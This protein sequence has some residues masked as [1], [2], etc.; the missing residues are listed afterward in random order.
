MKDK[1]PETDALLVQ[2]HQQIE[3]QKK[4]GEVRSE[5]EDLKKIRNENLDEIDTLE[6]EIDAMLSEEGII[7]DESIYIEDGC[8]DL[9]TDVDEEKIYAENKISNLDSI[10]GDIKDWESY[11]VSVRAYAERNN[12]DLDVDPFKSLMTESQRIEVSNRIQ[13]E[14]TYKKADCDKYDYMLAGTC[15]MIAGLVDIIFVGIPKQGSLGKK[16]DEAVDGAVQNF[17]KVL[18][19]QTKEGKDPTA[20]AIGFLEKKFKV[21]YDQTHTYKSGKAGT[22]GKVKNLYP[23]NHH[24]KSLG[25]SPDLIGLFFSILN[26]FTSTSTFISDG[27]LITINTETFELEGGN[28]PAKVYAGFCNWFGHLVS[29]VAGSSGARG[30]STRGSGIPIPFYALLQYIEVGKFGKNR[31]TFAKVSTKV[32]EQGYDFRHGVTMAIPVLISDLLSRLCWSMKQRLYHGKDWAE[33]LPSGSVPELRRMLLVSHGTLCIV[34]GADAGLRSGGNIVQLMLRTNVF[35]WAR[36]GTVA[37]KEV[38][39]YYKS[40]SLDIE[41]ANEHL[42]KEYEKLLASV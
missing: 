33:C 31:D 23:G 13:D 20:G 12:V 6:S 16:V 39:A 3:S 35:A 8:I 42:D 30:N 10:D 26:Q 28:F 24:L 2:R 17:A 7:F 27:K 41:A 40:E 9:L 11:L 19:W 14:L 34:D 22:D 38:V 15:G 21:N 5:I 36:F 32:F 4:I 18:G 37:A 25:H 1:K 29:D